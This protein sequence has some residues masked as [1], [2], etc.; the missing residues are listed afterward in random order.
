MKTT[1]WMLLAL[2]VAVP[3]SAHAQPAVAPPAACPAIDA[4]LP[5]DLA[6][7]KTPTR[8]VAAHSAAGAASVRL[9]PGI[10]TALALPAS[11]NV[12]YAIAP[13]KPDDV[14][15]HGGLAGFTIGAAGTYRIA[16]SSGAWIDVARDGKALVSVGHGHGPACSSIHKVVDFSLQ[17]GDYLLQLSAAPDPDARVLIQ[18]LP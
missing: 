10:A 14:T 15:A 2:L 12:S 3:A 5:A 1:P 6:A 7:W 11:A 16:L 13:T 4:A 8:L 17:P 18:R 9:K